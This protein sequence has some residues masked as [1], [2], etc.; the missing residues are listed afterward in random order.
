MDKVYVVKYDHTIV[1]MTLSRA[2]AEELAC[3]LTFENGHY[4]YNLMRNLG[5]RSHEKGMEE[6]NHYMDYI[7]VWEYELI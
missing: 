3:D 7:R 1:A 6:A 5:S 2:D 4:M